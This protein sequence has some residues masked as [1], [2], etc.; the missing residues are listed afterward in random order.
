MLPMMNWVFSHTELGSAVDVML[1]T[2]PV[3]RAIDVSTE[4]WSPAAM[5]VKFDLILQHCPNVFGSE[6]QQYMEYI[7]R[8]AFSYRRSETDEVASYANRLLL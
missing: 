6:V 5:Q 2:D 1:P 4:R 3:Y 7:G 8:L